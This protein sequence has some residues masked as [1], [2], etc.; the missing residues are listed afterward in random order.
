MFNKDLFREGSIFDNYE[1]NEDQI[2]FGST[3]N[4]YKAVNKNTGQYFAL[5]TIDS[6]KVDLSI[7]KSELK[8]LQGLT[9]PNIVKVFEYYMEKTENGNIY[10]IV[11]ELMEGGEVIKYFNLTLKFFTK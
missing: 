7:I 6:D 8:I 10:I 9:H 5:K 11:L 1:F 3:S 4:V 2:G